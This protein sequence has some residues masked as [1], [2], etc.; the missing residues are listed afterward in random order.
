MGVAERMERLI[1]IGIGG[2]LTGFGV[3]WGLGA[4][5]W[6]LAVLSVVTAGQRIWHV[7]SQERLRQENRAEAAR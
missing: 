1:L 4:A 7:R 5:L 2:L 6:I 3:D